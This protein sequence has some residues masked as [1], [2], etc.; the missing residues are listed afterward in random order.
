MKRA[1]IVCGLVTAAILAGCGGRGSSAIPQTRNEPSLHQG[2][3]SVSVTV[4]VPAPP[5]SGSLRQSHYISPGTKS[6]SFFAT[7]ND[8]NFLDRTSLQTANV[9]PGSTGCVTSGGNLVC[10]LTF[11][12]LGGAVTYTVSAYDGANGTGNV[13]GTATAQATW[14]NGANNAF[15]ITLDGVPATYAVFLNQ[16]TLPQGTPTD[17]ALNVT[18][19]DAAGDVIVNSPSLADSGGNPETASLADTN[20]DG[21][22]ISLSGNTTWP[23][24]GL[25]VHYD[26]GFNVADATFTVTTYP[27]T[28]PSSTATLDIGP[29]NNSAAII[30]TGGCCSNGYTWVWGFPGGASGQYVNVV[31]EPTY[32]SSPCNTGG[33]F[34]GL[35]TDA[36]NRLAYAVTG[37]CGTQDIIAQDP[38]GK[39]EWSVTG[40]NTGGGPSTL[41]SDILSLGFDS[42]N[43]IYA[44]ENN[45]PLCSNGCTATIGSINILKAGSNGPFST[46]MD[47]RAIDCVN[48]PEAIAVAADGTVYAAHIGDGNTNLEAIEVFAPGTSGY[49]ECSGSEVA[50]TPAVTAE[51]SIGGTNSGLDNVT[52]LALDGSGNLYAANDYANSITVY[53]PS[54]NGNV[55]PNRTITGPDTGISGPTGVGIDAFGNIYVVN[56]HVADAAAPTI[57]VYAPGASGDAKPVRTLIPGTYGWNNDIALIK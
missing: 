56:S 21:G 22:K 45:G 5:K 30:Y 3:A 40:L 51:R 49:F 14:V 1:H 25:T 32:P 19:Y 47:L 31:D 33:S 13:L 17:D 24:N 11:G 44:Y 4:V 29:P 57:T 53:G 35:S 50:G 18:A 10:T 36:Q 46:S 42:S 28:V 39:V 7:L 23:F 9:T 38:G 27:A 16:S 20:V 12:A 15:T 41:P 8:G 55:A 2:S 43:N 52:Q 6:I 34:Q 48:N 54:A 26:G 37:S